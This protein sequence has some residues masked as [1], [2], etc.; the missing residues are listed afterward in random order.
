MPAGSIIQEGAVL[1]P[2]QNNTVYTV[3]AGLQAVFSTIMIVNNDGSQRD[4]RVAIAAGDTPT[5]AEWITP[6]TLPIPA[7]DAN[8][9]TAGLTAAAGDR[10]VAWCETGADVVV[11][12]FGRLETAPG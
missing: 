3:P 8:P 9:I 4:V 2:A 6:Q 10:I 12:V 1:T 5:A 11:R 7:N